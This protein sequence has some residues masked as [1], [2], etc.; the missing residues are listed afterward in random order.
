MSPKT[1]PRSTQIQQEILDRCRRVETRLTK[2]LE[3][4]GFDTQ[5]RRPVWHPE[6][7]V[8]VPSPDVSITHVLDTIPD[9]WGQDADATRTVRVMH[10]GQLLARLTRD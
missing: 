10:K 2:F 8:D 1:A 3:L 5:V 6:G 9:T 7:I 4:Q